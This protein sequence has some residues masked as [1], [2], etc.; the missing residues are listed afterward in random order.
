MTSL[1]IFRVNPRLP[2]WTGKCMQC[3][4]AHR[5]LDSREE[6]TM[7]TTMDVEVL[8]LCTRTVT[9][10]PITIPAMGLDIMEL[11]LK[12]CPATFPEKSKCIATRTLGGQWIHRLLPRPAA[13]AGG[14]ASLQL[15]SYLWNLPCASSRSCPGVMS[16][17]CDLAPH[18]PLHPHSSSL[19]PTSSHTSAISSSSKAPSSLLWSTTWPPFYLAQWVSVS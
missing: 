10:T 7:L 9:S 14:E 6:A 19:H 11:L 17:L 4:W 15:G 5:L 3:V 8:E 2:S 12:N 18:V 16:P 13:G 1:A